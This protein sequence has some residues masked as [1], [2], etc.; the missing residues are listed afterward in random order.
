[1]HAE[2]RPG[3]YRRVY[4]GFRALSLVFAAAHVLVLVLYAGKRLS[5]F[6]TS[7]VSIAFFLLLLNLA[8]AGTLGW[9]GTAAAPA[10]SPKMKRLLTV[11]LVMT[12]IS[13]AA[14][15]VG[16]ATEA[17][18]TLVSLVVAVLVAITWAGVIFVVLPSALA[19]PPSDSTETPPIPET[20]PSAAPPAADQKAAVDCGQCIMNMLLGEGKE[21]GPSLPAGP[22]LPPAPDAA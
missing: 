12:M 2:P 9:G 7:V 14:W 20:P 18:P 6:G 3:S 11:L 22:S 15:L 21:S 1:M 10:L 16:D 13:L 5:G 4:N 17:L 8:L 19:A